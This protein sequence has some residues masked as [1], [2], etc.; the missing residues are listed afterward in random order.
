MGRMSPVDSAFLLAENRRQPLHV[1]GLQLFRPPADA[2]A[3][4]GQQLAER[5]RQSAAASAPFNRRPDRR[6]GLWS[7]SE[8]E[9]FDVEQHFVHLSLPRPGRMEDLLAL[10]SHLHSTPLDRAYPLWCF[11][12]I[13]G[14]EDGRIALFS[15]LH[16]AVADGVANVRLMLGAM[17]SDA[18]RSTAMTAPWATSG[19]S[20][21]GNN[22]SRVAPGRARTWLQAAQSGI[23]STPAVLANVRRAVRDFRTANPDLVTSFQ[24]P[25][26]ILNTRISGSR[27]VAVQSYPT[28]R[29]KAI[30]KRCDATCN[31]VVLALCGSALRRYLS[32]LDALPAKPLIAVV[33]VS[34]RRDQSAEGNQLAATLANLGTDHADPVQRLRTVKG[35]MDYAKAMLKGMSPGQIMAYTA[36]MMAP[37]AAT[38]I[39]GLLPGRSP[40]NVVISH[41]RGPDQDMYWQGCRLVGAYP[42]SVVL[43]GFALN[44][45][46]VRRDSHIDLGVVACRRTLPGAGDLLGY[47]EDG[48]AELE[49]ALDLPQAISNTSG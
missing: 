19:Q 29:I 27:R 11:Y 5:L 42:A 35:S 49:S 9:A 6:R 25:R 24:A 23:A 10:V 31:D 43:D 14:L 37:G 16:H 47:F 44:L 48:I 39:P 2:D 34:I 26:C 18:Q 40:A 45:T 7:W 1:G 30:A 4:F 12:L 17:S 13:E 22:H 28:A 36:A 38:L 32:K 21:L 33:P 3:D 46:L 8:A 15:K 20:L 41:M